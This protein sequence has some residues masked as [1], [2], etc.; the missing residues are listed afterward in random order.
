MKQESKGGMIQMKY[1][2][3]LEH[4]LAASFAGYSW[5]QFSDLTGDGAWCEADEDN[6]AMVIATFRAHQRMG[7]LQWR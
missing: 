5:L 6:K 4:R 7:G 3:V 2:N 1:N